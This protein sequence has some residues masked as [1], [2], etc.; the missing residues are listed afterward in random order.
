M[1]EPR[2][3]P[4]AGATPAEAGGLLGPADVL[5]PPVGGRAGSIR[6]RLEDGA[7]AEVRPA[8]TFPYAP[9]AGDRLLV[10]GR[11]A[12]EGGATR[13]FAIGVIA[14]AGQSSL[15]MQ[16]DVDLRAVGGTL[17]LAGDDG[18]EVDAP[19][20][21]LRAELIRTFAG[22]LSEKTDTAYRWV[23]DLL[24]VRAGS[25]RRVVAGEDHSQSRSS[26][27]LAEE[28]LKLDAHSVHLGH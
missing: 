18:V 19:K 9:A 11:G 6:V 3:N 14:G 10:A 28:T 17:H 24:T 22:T 27:T 23:K 1:T 16:G 26:V 13:L 8:F 7:E 20:V 5:D 21:T 25:S 15:T 4:L 12:L 2:P